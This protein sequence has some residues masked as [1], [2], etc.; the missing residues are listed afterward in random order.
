MTIEINSSFTTPKP[1]LKWSA[2]I[3]DEL[4]HP[5]KA[6]LNA[7]EVTIEGK[8]YPKAYIPL[9]ELKAH[10]L[11]LQAAGD[12]LDSRDILEAEI[13]AKLA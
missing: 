8:T 1:K 2:K 11:L 12:A 10:L 7:H 5:V 13:A 3:D 9:T 6:Q 4:G